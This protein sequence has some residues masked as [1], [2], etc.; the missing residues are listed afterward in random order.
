M[1]QTVKDLINAQNEI[2]SKGF[3]KGILE[4]SVDGPCCMLGAVYRATT[5]KVVTDSWG[6]HRKLFHTRTENALQA[7]EIAADVTWLPTFND[8]QKTTKKMVLE[9]FDEA[10]SLALSEGL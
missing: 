7:L 9:K 4:D 3:C 5:R 10:I 8:R 1:T 6:F 2:R